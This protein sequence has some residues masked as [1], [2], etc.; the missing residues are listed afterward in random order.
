MKLSIGV[1]LTAFVVSISNCCDA[2]PEL[3][4]ISDEQHTLP[5]DQQIW[6]RLLEDTSFPQPTREPAR[7][8]TTPPFV[9]PGPPTQPPNGGGL[10]CDLQP[11][12]RAELLTEIAEGVSG[13]I[14]PG[15]PQGRAL[16]WLI[17][18]DG[19]LVC[20]DDPKVYQ[21]YILAL[22]YFA[23]DGDNWAECSAPDNFDDPESIAEAN[24]NCS[25]TTTPIAGGNQNPSF[26]ETT[27]GTDAWLTPVYECEWAGI[28]CRVDGD[29]VDRI[30]FGK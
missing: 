10:I 8:P 4:S 3:R 16:A 12:R 6:K 14:T 21:R 5:E 20:P 1:Y 25:I 26:K 22:F 13:P 2:A 15:T 19:Y 27:E 29:C 23:T 24:D 28:T 18:S 7:R 11:I 9:P 17:R 30:E